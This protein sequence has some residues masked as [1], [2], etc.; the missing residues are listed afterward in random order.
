VANK[1]N[2][3]KFPKPEADD[4][5]DISEYNKAM[6]ILDD[7]LTEMDQKKLDKNG[8]ASEVVTEFQQEILRENIESGET[9]SSV[10]GKVKKWFTEMKDVAFSGHAKDIITDAAHRFV[11]DVEKS[12]W[13]GKVGATGGDISETNIDSLESITTEFPVPDQGETTKIFM[14]KVKKFI[15]D[16]N[17]FKSGIITV[18]KLVNSGST[19]LGGYALDARYGKTL[20]DLYTQLNS[21]L[22]KNEDIK[23]GTILDFIIANK[24]NKKDTFIVNNYI[25]PDAPPE[26]RTSLTEGYIQILRGSNGNRTKVLYY[27]YGTNCLKVWHRSIFNNK[28]LDDWLPSVTTAELNKKQDSLILPSDTNIDYADANLSKFG[29]WILPDNSAG[30][31]NLKISWGLLQFKMIRGEVFIRYQW[32]LSTPGAW[33]KIY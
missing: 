1:T 14:G 26:F 18:G 15:Q 20:F 24:E 32:G 12:S 7:S 3:Y 22:G 4:F 23:T 21:D 16:F 29:G 5:Y 9:L 2:N 11:S 25:P 27:E 30:Y 6:D 28:W 13:N 19:T 31:F 17:N 8:D 10:F 33:K